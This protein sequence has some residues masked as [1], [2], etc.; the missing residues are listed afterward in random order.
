[1]CS[2]VRVELAVGGSRERLRR[3]TLMSVAGQGG[4][5]VQ[6]VADPAALMTMVRVGGRPVQFRL[7]E[8]VLY[9]GSYAAE[10][11]GRSI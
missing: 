3:Y 8:T 4:R 2:V 5:R 1:M 6:V 9:D 10:P 11:L 7:T